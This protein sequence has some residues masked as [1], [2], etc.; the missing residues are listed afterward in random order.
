MMR[1]NGVFDSA[2]D[3][4]GTQNDQKMKSQLYVSCKVAINYC[5]LF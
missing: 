3:A 4:F 5:T 1:S 2:N